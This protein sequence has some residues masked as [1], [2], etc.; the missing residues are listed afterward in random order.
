MRILSSTSLV[1]ALLGACAEPAAS[2]ASDAEVT[3]TDAECGARLGAF[4][5]TTTIE[6]YASVESG[7]TRAQKLSHMI[8]PALPVTQHGDR[9]HQGAVFTF[10]MN[11]GT[12]EHPTTSCGALAFSLPGVLLY[13]PLDAEGD[14]F[15]YQPTL[16][17]TCT[18]DVYQADAYITERKVYGPI[19]PPADSRCTELTDHAAFEAALRNALM[20]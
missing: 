6:R 10:A 4:L 14:L 19:T 20:P 7:W 3:Q 9:I 8:G 13:P 18:G 2:P 5:R 15:F 16:I 17:D 1:V 12:F 11:D